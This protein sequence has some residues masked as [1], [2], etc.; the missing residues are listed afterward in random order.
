MDILSCLK[1]IY[2][3]ISQRIFDPYSLTFVQN[4]KTGA[5]VPVLPENF[6]DASYVT[7][8]LIFYYSLII[9]NTELQRKENNW[10]V[11]MM[12]K[13]LLNLGK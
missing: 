10:T 3:A 13:I 9:W 5:K 1:S 4:F 7:H 8:A 12:K 6:A 11:Y 2:L